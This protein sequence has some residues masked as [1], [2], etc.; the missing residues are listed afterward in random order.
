[1]VAYA[2]EKKQLVLIEKYL[3]ERGYGL[4]AHLAAFLLNQMERGT[5]PTHPDKASGGPFVTLLSLV[6]RPLTREQGRLAQ[7]VEIV[8]FVGLIK[9]IR[10]FCSV[11]LNSCGIQ[12][13]HARK[14]A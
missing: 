8:S 5:F 10:C 13:N 1:M 11:F 3:T 2:Q 14:K 4:K 9:I 12:R 7:V 6:L